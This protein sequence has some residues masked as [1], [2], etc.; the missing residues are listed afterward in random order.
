MAGEN[1][2]LRATLKGNIA[3]ADVVNMVFHYV[4]TTGVETDYSAIAVA[5][6]T[7]L[8]TAFADLEAFVSS[9]INMTQLDLSEWDFVDNEFDGKATA[10]VT[11]LIGT[12]ATAA[13]IDGA[14][15]VLRFITEE[16]RRQGRKFIP[17]L[18]EGDITDNALAAPL[19][20]AGLASA[21]ILND[22]FVAGGATLRPCTFNSTP[23]SPRFETESRF[24]PSAFVNA[25][26]GYQRNRQP[27]AGA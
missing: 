14:A 19:I 5:I 7:A 4:V 25:L 15:M 16:L 21:V 12:D 20:A 6:G 9:R 11:S 17:G 2:I 24:V 26:V 10:V 27:G 23:L 22:D 1:D 13:D 8:N 3:A 18:T